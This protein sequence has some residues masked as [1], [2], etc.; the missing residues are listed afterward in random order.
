MP[1]IL[2]PLF[3]L[4][5]VVHFPG[6]EL[7]L[8]I[9]EPRYRQLV[10]EL[11]ERPEEE[12]RIGMI[13]VHRDPDTGDVGLVEPGCA[14]RLVAHEPLDEGRSNI[15]LEGEFRFVVEREIEG[16]PYRRALVRV[17]DDQVPLLQAERAEQLAREISDLA[18][19]VAHESGDRFPV[20]LGTLAGLGRPERLLA[21]TNRLAAGL[22]LPALRKQSLLAEAPLERAEQVAGILR[23]RMKVLTSLRPYRHLAAAAERN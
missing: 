23:S 20:D 17:L 11:L 21:L 10:A 16:R 7:P 15:V 22:D 8:H 4:P 13:F 9:F 12:R 3:P 1:E 18:A 19:A 6:T 14:G 2:L 5:N